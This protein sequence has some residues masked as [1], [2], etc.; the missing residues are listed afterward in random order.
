MADEAEQPAEQAEQVEEQR[1]EQ[2][3]EPLGEAGMAALNRERE[4][5]AKAIEERDALA[6]RLQ[7]IEDRDKSETQKAIERAERAEQELVSARTESA[8]LSVMTKHGIPAEYADL[9]VGEGDALEQSAEKLARLFK[10]NGGPVV[11]TEGKQ[12]ESASQ[13]GDWLRDKLTRK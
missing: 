8:R 11:A 7:E 12:P 10:R 6:A 4:R 3:E 13:S 5:R 9:L 1:E 2:R